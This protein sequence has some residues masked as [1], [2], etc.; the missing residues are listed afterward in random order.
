MGRPSRRSQ[1]VGTQPNSRR[2]DS[3]RAR[4]QSVSIPAEAIGITLHWLFCW[5]WIID[6]SQTRINKMPARPPRGGLRLAASAWRPPLCRGGGAHVTVEGESNHGDASHVGTFLLCNGGGRGFG[7]RFRMRVK[8]C[9][10]SQCRRANRTAHSR[11]ACSRGAGR[12]GRPRRHEG[13]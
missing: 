9:R 8:T 7:R 1:A 2:F 10:T 11:S 4:S 6:V 3:I 5:L 12:P 13:N